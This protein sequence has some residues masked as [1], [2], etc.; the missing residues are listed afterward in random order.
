M[1]SCK[2]SL[3]D[4]STALQ[5]KVSE[6]REDIDVLRS[7]V[8]AEQVNRKADEKAVDE[9]RMQMQRLARSVFFIFFFLIFA[10]TVVRR[11]RMRSQ[12]WMTKSKR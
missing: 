7:Q 1:E 11:L 9:L 2:L 10:Q 6:N 12:D 4:F 3:N 5:R 8:K